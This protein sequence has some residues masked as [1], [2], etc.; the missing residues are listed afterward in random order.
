[1]KIQSDIQPNSKKL[2]FNKKRKTE[3]TDKVEEPKRKR[4][5]NTITP[6]LEK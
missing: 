4:T 2:N 3:K 5:K 1:M 6:E